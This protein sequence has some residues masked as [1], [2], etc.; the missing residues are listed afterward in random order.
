MGAVRTVHLFIRGEGR[1]R[2]S[3]TGICEL[4]TCRCCQSPQ[5]V[6]YGDAQRH[7][8][9]A[10]GPSPD[11]V[12]ATQPLQ[13]GYG[14]PNGPGCLNH[15]KV[16]VRTYLLHRYRI[17]INPLG[18]PQTEPRSASGG[19]NGRLNANLIR[20]CLIGG[21]RVEQHVFRAHRNLNKFE[22]SFGVLLCQRSCAVCCAARFGALP[23]QRSVEIG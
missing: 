10:T 20:W 23:C 19:R 16:R 1:T 11:I 15:G 13:L 21:F 18:V 17:P 7:P 22:V 3:A 8:H 5:Q 4:F 12:F 6:R 14:Y 9:H 2:V